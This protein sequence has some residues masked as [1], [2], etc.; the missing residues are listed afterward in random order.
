[1]NVT[2]QKHIKF[3]KCFNAAAS[4]AHTTWWGALGNGRE[5]ERESGENKNVSIT[6]WNGFKCT[7]VAGEQS[8]VEGGGWCRINNVKEK[9]ER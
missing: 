7:Q 3:Y 1:M 2:N 6:I 5:R 8:D 9:S 4:A